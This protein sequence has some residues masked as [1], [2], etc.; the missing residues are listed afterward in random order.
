MNILPKDWKPE[1]IV[2][3][4]IS[5]EVP[6]SGAMMLL[7]PTPYR[8]TFREPFEI[9]TLPDRPLYLDFYPRGQTRA[10]NED[11]INLIEKIAAGEDLSSVEDFSL[12]MQGNQK[13]TDK[14]SG[15]LNAIITTIDDVFS[16]AG[17]NLQ[18]AYDS[19]DLKQE[20]SERDISDRVKYLEANTKNFIKGNRIFA[21]LA[22]LSTQV[23]LLTYGFGFYKTSH[24]GQKYQKE[25]PK[26]IFYPSKLCWHYRRDKWI[27]HSGI[28]LN[29]V[30]ECL[31]L[32]ITQLSNSKP[33]I[34]F[35]RELSEKIHLNF[36]SDVLSRLVEALIQHNEIGLLEPAIAQLRV[37]EPFHPVIDAAEKIIRRSKV[38]AE[39]GR[40]LSSSVGSIQ[41][42]SGLDFEQFLSGQFRDKGFKVTLTKAS[43]DFG[44][45]L[46]VETPSGTRAAVQAKRF[47]SKVNLKAVQEVVG[48]VSHY[49][50]DFGIVIAASGF[51][52]SAVDLAK[53]NQVELWDDDKLF[54][55]LSGDWTFSMLAD[56]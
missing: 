30:I 53:T 35:Y 55:F 25:A 26:V 56:T 6:N 41:E 37:L 40:G 14:A 54:R 21:G 38:F 11:L 9:K 12:L 17:V 20:K 27:D 16:E 18:G 34:S 15:T 2:N 43:G 31:L 50:A 28:V 22:Y 39:I 46:I 13:I 33:L 51:F 24:Y 42:M 1:K 36:K 5:D 4:S 52:P 32:L 7:A 3:Y 8:I 44:A 47:K 19:T 23:Q 49:A 45:D 48:S 10:E 29:K